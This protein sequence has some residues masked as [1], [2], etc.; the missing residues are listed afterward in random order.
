LLL[1]PRRLF[2]LVAELADMANMDVLLRAVDNPGRRAGWYSRR[3]GIL[4][5]I[6]RG[7]RQRRRVLRKSF[8]CG[9]RFPLPAGLEGL[10]AA[11]EVRS[12]PPVK[13]EVWQ[14]LARRFLDGQ[15][16]TNKNGLI[17][18]DVQKLPC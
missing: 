13:A 17:A 3:G 11:A 7:Q 10:L 12:P 14:V 9:D 16:T 5:Y 8:A 4:F 2:V 1:G 18:L 15:T 6:F